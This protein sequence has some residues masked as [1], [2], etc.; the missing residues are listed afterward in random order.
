MNLESL[1]ICFN[2]SHDLF[3]SVFTNLVSSNAIASSGAV[4][5]L[6]MVILEFPFI[7]NDPVALTLIL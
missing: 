6:V 5:D 3:E 7:A 4:E 2:M 1:I